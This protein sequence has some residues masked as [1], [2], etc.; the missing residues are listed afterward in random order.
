MI[1]TGGFWH[2]KRSPKCSLCFQ[3]VRGLG[4]IHDILHVGRM[5]EVCRWTAHKVRCQAKS[6]KS[7]LD[8][9]VAGGRGKR[10]RVRQRESSNVIPATLCSGENKYLGVCTGMV[11]F[12]PTFVYILE[13]KM[14]LM[15]ACALEFRVSNNEQE[16]ANSNRRRGQRRTG[17]K[18]LRYDVLRCC[19][20]SFQMFLSMW[21]INKRKIGA[22][23]DLG[24]A[25]QEGTW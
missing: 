13:W 23:R 22:K 3:D 7:T 25:H 6:Q 2:R 12:P 19:C 17:R 14:P 5:R 18:L 9:S 1:L 16:P 8:N 4:N 21:P 10:V 11:G 20:F 24:F 15:C